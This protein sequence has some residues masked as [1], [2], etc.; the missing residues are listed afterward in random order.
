[1]NSGE[2]RRANDLRCRVVLMRHA[3]PVQEGCFIGQLDVRLSEKGRRQLREVAQKLSPY[4]IEAIYSSDLLRARC[5]A[6]AAARA[7]RMHVETRPGF[8]EMHFGVWQGLS[9]K[10]IEKRFPRRARRWLEEFPQG[11]IP[12]AEPFT[13]FRKRVRQ[14]LRKIIAMHPGG[15][16][17]VVT[18]AGVIRSFLAQALGVRDWNL[19]RMA[20]DYCGLSLIDYLEDEASVRCVNG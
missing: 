4:R 7:G 1:M 15:C 8:R 9:W 6:E 10:Q 5:T 3:A 14:E 19:F 17:L 2:R 18:H 12:G 16:V 13:E 20:Q 11:S